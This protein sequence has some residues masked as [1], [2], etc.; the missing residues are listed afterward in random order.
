MESLKVVDKELLT[1]KEFAQLSGRTKQAIY[2]QLNNKLSPF[3]QTINNQKMLETRALKEI[4]NIDIEQQ[5]DEKLNDEI[6]LESCLEASLYEILKDELEA[7]N[8]QII[9]LQGELA[10]ER[11]HN[12][13][14]ADKIAIF[15]DQAQKLQLAQMKP[16]ISE[17]E[18]EPKKKGLFKRLFKL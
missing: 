14:Q 4:F 9:H 5:K 1:V 18:E 8:K 7:K 3:V 13:E 6:N 17:N 10:T 2:K 11:Q 12:R 15:A 16:Q